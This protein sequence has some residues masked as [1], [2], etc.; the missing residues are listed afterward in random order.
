MIVLL[1]GFLYDR[2]FSLWTELR[3]VDLERNP[4]WT[5]ALSPTWMMSLAT[6]AQVMKN[7]T[8]DVKIQQDADWILN[9][10]KEYSQNEMFARS[11]QHWDK[12]LKTTPTFWFL[13]EKIM[14]AARSLKIEDDD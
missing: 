2:V 14:E 8:D 9:W 4:Y 12:Y 11:V 10:C 7:T 6:N 13:D 5:Y 1:I 3:S